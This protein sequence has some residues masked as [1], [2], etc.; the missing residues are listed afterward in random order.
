V[1]TAH[2]LSADSVFNFALMPGQCRHANDIV[3]SLVVANPVLC[4]QKCRE[5]DWCHG[6]NIVQ[7][8]SGLACQ[9]TSTKATPKF[10]A[11][12]TGCQYFVRSALPK[13]NYCVN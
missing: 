7:S 11:S 10:D 6:F 4:V 2:F 1:S 12:T 9:L 8:A 13:D 5:A 3:E